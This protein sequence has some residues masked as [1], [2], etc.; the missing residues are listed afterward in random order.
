MEKYY[1]AMRAWGAAISATVAIIAAFVAT[2]ALAVGWH[3]YEDKMAVDAIFE[4]NRQ[5]PPNSAPCLR[6]LVRLE[7]KDWSEIVNRHEVPLA[8]ELKDYVLGCLSDQSKNELLELYDDTNNKLTRRGAAFIVR[9]TNQMFNADNFVA[10]LIIRKIGNTELY[11][12][13]GQANLSR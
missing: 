9:R 10:G 6:F 8:E 13:I 2:G 4:W 7:P 5:R 11:Q 12:T 1:D 3:N